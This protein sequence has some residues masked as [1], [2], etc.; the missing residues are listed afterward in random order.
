MWVQVYKF[1]AVH[2]GLDYVSG[3]GLDS[4]VQTLRTVTMGLWLEEVAF[5]DAG[6]MLLC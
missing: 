6:A 2:L 5:D 4:G 1:R 3:S